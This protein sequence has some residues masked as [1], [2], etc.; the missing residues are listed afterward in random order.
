MRTFIVPLYKGVAILEFSSVSG[1][2][3]DA[4]VSTPPELT[5]NGNLQVSEDSSTSILIFGDGSITVK[6]EQDHG[7][8]L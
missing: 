6:T 8:L 3:K 5:L 1:D 7:G 4:D 2:I